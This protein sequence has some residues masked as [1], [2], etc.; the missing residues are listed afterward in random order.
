MAPRERDG[1][2]ELGLVVR[3]RD[4]D[5]GAEPRRLDED[6]VAERVLD[7]VA[8]PQRHVARNRDAAVAQ[9]G[10]EEVLVHA[11]RGGGDP[12]ADVGDAGEL[13]QALDRAVLAER[14][15][16][17][18]QDDVDGAERL[19]RLRVGEHGQRLRDAT[20]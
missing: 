1:G 3:L 2:F 6:G 18:G 9:H 20:L 4:P 13:E 14:A 16:Q 8:E 10:L 17:H 15:V 12:G 5:R 19:G 11:E 7:L